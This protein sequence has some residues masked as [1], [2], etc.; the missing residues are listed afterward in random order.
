MNA[1]RTTPTFFEFNSR[2]A[3]PVIAPVQ[4]ES[5]LRAL[6]KANLEE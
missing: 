2:I 1:K 4:C 3:S 6:S 5:K